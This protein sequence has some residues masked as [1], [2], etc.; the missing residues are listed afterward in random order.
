MTIMKARKL[1]Q[2]LVPAY[3]LIHESLN[4]YSHYSIIVLRIKIKN[5]REFIKI[6]KIELKMKKINCISIKLNIKV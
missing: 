5:D 2:K 3:E 6:R 1:F 4:R